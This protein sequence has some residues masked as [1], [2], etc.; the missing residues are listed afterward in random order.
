MDPSRSSPNRM[1]PWAFEFDTPSIQGYAVFPNM[2]IWK[3]QG[4]QLSSPGMIWMQISSIEKRIPAP[5]SIAPSSCSAQLELTLKPLL[6]CACNSLEAC[7]KSVE[8]SRRASLAGS[9]RYVPDMLRNSAEAGISPIQKTALVVQQTIS[10]TCMWL[11]IIQV[12]AWGC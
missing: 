10:S 1:A 3:E 8:I 5:R 7:L 6:V 9:P 12:S 4:P 11:M 2:A